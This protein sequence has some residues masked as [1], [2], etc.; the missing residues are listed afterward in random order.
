MST[1]TYDI[2]QLRSWTQD[3]LTHRDLA[4]QTLVNTVQSTLTSLNRAWAFTRVEAPIMMPRAM[5][6]D[7]YSDDD[8]W[9]LAHQLNA[10]P[11]AL[12][13]E[14]TPTTYQVI[15][16]LYPNIAHMKLPYCFW[17]VGLSFRQEPPSKANRLRFYQFTQLE[18]QCL[19]AEGT[20]ADYRAKSIDAIAQTLG[21][22]CKADH[23]VVESDRL[24]SYA[25][26]TLD[27]E[28]LHNDEWREVASLSY[29]TDFDVPNFEIAIGLD[30][31]M[32]IAIP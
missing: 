22:L 20:K 10:E 30:R 12:R 6:S 1:P 3:H 2:A 31:I 15:R 17:Q 32:A 4:Q 21:W 14:T 7:A 28:V 25:S 23:R 5:M 29:R 26:S 18:F 24:P 13:A 27:V 8:I 11:F 9:P 19:F 16:S